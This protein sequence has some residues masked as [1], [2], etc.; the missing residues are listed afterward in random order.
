M[1]TDQTLSQRLMA[2]REALR[3]RRRRR[4]GWA[5]TGGAVA[6]GAAL[7]LWVRSPAPPVVQPW[8]G[9]LPP[10]SG[11]ATG[12]DTYVPG[13]HLVW[14]D[15]FDNPHLTARLWN[16]QHL[17]YPYNNQLQF[18]RRQAVTV[19]G[20]ALHITVSHA[21]YGGRPYTSGMLTTQGRFAFR[22]GM[23][24]IRARLPAGQGLFPAIWMLPVA[25]PPPLPEVD[26]MESI[27]RTP[28]HVYMTLHYLRNGAQNNVG[29]YYAGP[30]FTTTF[31]TFALLWS[32][33]ELV[34]EVDGVTRETITSGVPRVR[35]YLI[36]NVAV[37]GAFPGSPNSTDHW[38][39]HFV[40]QYV[41][42]YKSGSAPAIPGRGHRVALPALAWA[43]V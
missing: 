23:V 27:G 40:V 13:W 2:M 34:W 9:P 42:I 22:Y 31:H 4:I 36:L 8:E 43:R 15:E 16:I 24:V 38:P 35:M 11:V 29:D 12:H 18:Y 14:D 32:P 10:V 37:G 25:Q 28:H 30:N 7:L 19:S 33:H 1:G 41:R 3:R 20:G 26:I 17:A 21:A 5:L 39:Q 6:I